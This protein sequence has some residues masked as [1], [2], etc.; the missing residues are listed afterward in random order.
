MSS[1]E[2]LNYVQAGPLKRLMALIYDS[3]ILLAIAFCYGWIVLMLKYKLFD[4]PLP[5]S[6]HAEMGGLAAL[7]L[8]LALVTFYIYFWLKG[9]QTLGMKAWRLKLLA[10]TNDAPQLK[11]CLIRCIAAPL[12]ILTGCFGFIWCWID[13]DGHALQDRLSHTQVVMLEK[14][15]A[16]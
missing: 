4:I 5:E 11:H 8:I 6:G 16:N 10:D 12:C 2:N 15:K 1:P 9:G 13:R 7:G 14:K 3:L